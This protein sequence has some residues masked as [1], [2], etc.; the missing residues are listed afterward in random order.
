MKSKYLSLSFLALL[1]VGTFAVES[2]AHADFVSDESFRLVAQ[3]LINLKSVPVYDKQSGV[4]NIS[5]ETLAS[6][7]KMAADQAEIWGDTILEES[8]EAADEIQIDHVDSLSNGESLVA[9]RI[10]YSQQA[11]DTS[12]CSYTDNPKASDQCRAGR[13]VEASLVS[14]NLTSWIMDPNVNAHF[15][16]K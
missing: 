1:V 6:F 2:T 5:V 4:L 16:T 3:S 10:V 15:E 11:W 12:T 8:Y 7:Q 9:Y 13:I 14:P